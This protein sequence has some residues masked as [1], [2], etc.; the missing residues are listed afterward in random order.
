MEQT[1][2]ERTTSDTFRL[3]PLA[4]RLVMAPKVTFQKLHEDVEL[5]KQGSINS[6][7]FDVKAYLRNRPVRIMDG[8]NRPYPFITFNDSLRLQPGDRALIPLGF[9]AT[10]PAEFVA[11]VYIRSGMA[12]KKGLTLAN[13]VGIID[14]DYPDEWLV[15]VQNAG[16]SSVTIDHGERIAQVIFERWNF[17]TF[18]EGQ[19]GVTTDR[20]GGVGSTGTR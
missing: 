14:A 7:G 6:A 19:V 1:T 9:K 13:N 18:V 5:P 3:D 17:V 15:L 2:L 20:T 8:D 10:M 16:T 11:K 12:F 4:Q